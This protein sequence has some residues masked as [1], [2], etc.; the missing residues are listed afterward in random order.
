VAEAVP[1]VVFIGEL[2][3][4]SLIPEPPS[5]HMVL[6]QSLGLRSTCWILRVSLTSVPSS[7]PYCDYCHQPW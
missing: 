1:G 3:V 6:I 2:E 7:S 5:Q 4:R